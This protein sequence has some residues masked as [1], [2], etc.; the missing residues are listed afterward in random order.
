MF[1]EIIYQFQNIT[2]YPIYEFLARYENFMSFGYPAM[3]RYF[4]GETE[5]IDGAYLNQLTQLT[6]DC[7]DVI[8]LFNSFANKLQN[9]G[10]WELLEYFQNLNDEIERV[11]KLP[12]FLRS[13]KSVRGYT[14]TIQVASSIGG[15]RTVEDVADLVTSINKDSTNWVDIMLNN[16]LN[17]DDWEIDELSKVNVY[18]NTNKVVV[19]T[20]L[21]QPIGKR[22]YGIDIQRKI[23]FANNDLQVVVHEANIEQKCNIL[24][25][26]QVGDVPENKLFGLNAF[27]IG[28]DVKQYSYPEFVTEIVNTFMQDDLFEQVEVTNFDFSNGDLTAKLEI[29]TKYDYKTT[30][31]V[32]I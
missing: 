25:T 29:K 19:E 26:L 14:P 5:N 3:K 10:Y 23:E 22:V 2:K 11:H 4:N 15:M 24:C 20:I 1:T 30:N 6:T 21:D 31:K 17:E 16:D 9:C 12:K 32:V 18:V 28:S 8:T 7:R 13:S 27:T